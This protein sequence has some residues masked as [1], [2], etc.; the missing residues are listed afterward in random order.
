MTSHLAQVPLW[1]AIVIA[2]LVVLGSGLTLL[3]ALGLVRLSSFFDRIHAPTLGTSWGTAGVML[4][5]ALLFTLTG[6]RLVIHEIVIG[7]LMMTTTP[8]TLM[9]LGR[10][11]LSRN[12]GARPRAA[13][14]A[15][16]TAGLDADAAEGGSDRR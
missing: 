8:V 3:G 9:I 6:D 4:G 2:V 1:A 13:N 16:I 10:A 7:A 11:A 14:P 5:S 15:S 12:G